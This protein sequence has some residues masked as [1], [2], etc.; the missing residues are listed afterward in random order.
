MGIYQMGGIVSGVG[1]GMDSYEIRQPL[2][3]CAGIAPFN[4]PVMCPLW[5]VPIAVATGNTF[6]LK[7]SERDAGA[8]VMLAQLAA[9]AGLPPGVLN[10]VQ[11]THEVVNYFCDAPPIKAVAFVGSN[12][13]GE[14]I[15]RRANANGKRVQANMGAKNHTSILPDAGRKHAVSS[16]TGAAFGAA[17]QRCMALSVAILV[18]EA[19]LWL[20]D[21]IESARALKVGS[22]FD[23]SVDV[24][25]MISPEALQRAEALIE[26]AVKQGATVA[27]D[28]RG[29]KV[30]GFPNGNFLGPTVVTGVTPSMDIYKE[31]VF[32]PVLC[33]MEADSL[34]ESIDIIN[35]NEYGNG[36]SIFTSSGHHARRFQH[37]VEPGQVGINVAIPVALPMFSFSG[38]KKSFWGDLNMYGRMGVS[39][40][41]RAQTVTAVWPE[42]GAAGT[43]TTMFSP[44]K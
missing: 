25:P 32:G 2:G 15:Y 16:V 20:P 40:Y 34:D 10:V 27:L 21:I 24:G 12:R 36:T 42:E 37:A 26:S 33:V 38:A 28:G 11:G 17:G 22:G 7:P 43:G 19:R 4:F 29:V 14:H 35:A 1:R 18:G 41:T 13:A 8:A 6:L 39:F 9:E 44:G 31:E 5:M 23:P 30:D 3:V